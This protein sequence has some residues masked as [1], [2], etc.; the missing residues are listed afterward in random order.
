MNL[1]FKIIKNC[2]QDAS[3]IKSGDADF[4][5]ELDEWNDFGYRVMYHLHATDKL[6]RRGNE[7]LGYFKIMKKG[8]KEHEY[9]FEK[10]MGVEREFENFPEDYISF[11]AS[12]EV[13]QSLHR[14]LHRSERL[15]F[16][17]QTHLILGY[18]SPFYEGIL[19]DDCFNKAILRDT[20]L[21]D[22]SLIKGSELLE[23]KANFYNLQ[24]QE[25]KVSFPSMGSSVHLRFT[26]LDEVDNELLPNGI[27][28][29]IGKNGSG[30]STLLYK[31]AKLMY[32][33]PDQRY[34]LE[35][36]V[37]SLF[38]NDIGLSKLF[39]VSYSPFD[40]FVLPGIGREDYK[41]LVK[42]MEHNEG[43]LIFCGIR[44]VKRELEDVLYQFED[45]KL[46]NLF[47]NSRQ[48][49]TSLK[50]NE[51]LAS[52]FVEAMNMITN[53]EEKMTLWKNIYMFAKTN[54][55]E[56]SEEMQEMPLHL[57]D[58]DR[59]EAFMNL[60]TG[61]K[62]YFHSLARIIAYID[63]DCMIL[64]DEPENHVHPP[65]LSFMMACLRMILNKYRSVMLVATHSPVV[66]Q[67]TF[68]DNVFIVRRSGGTQIINHPIIETYGANISEITSEV[69]DLTTDI[70]NYYQA[71]KTLYEEWGKKENWQ[72][73][74]EM[75]TS[76]RRHLNG[77]ISSQQLSYLISLYCKEHPKQ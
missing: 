34:K 59:S 60:S 46:D 4:L 70:T 47:Q 8:Q 21:H 69:F 77:K 1:K 54:F 19:N 63:Y 68:S 14:L 42:N 65:M 56:I 39:I 3:N 10:E 76:F 26:G 50:S 23:D 22:F 6:T 67:E 29:F 66:I 20:T 28:A 72:S 44:D 52:E 33:S 7:Y 32:A 27:V 48:A 12:I 17:N 35:T 2:F 25:L 18:D 41:L 40:N 9:P 24:E 38:P 71:Y 37:G 75:V 30:K 64:F 62:F 16:V 45:G 61:V 15:S 36:S 57:T 74:N 51:T 73:L 11:T 53:D 58:D 43:R 31:I 49:L 13:Y 5:I 55:I